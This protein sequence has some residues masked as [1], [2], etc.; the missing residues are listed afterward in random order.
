MRKLILKLSCSIIGYNGAGKSTLLHILSGFIK[1]TEGD[2]YCNF[3]D[4]KSKLNSIGFCSQDNTALPQNTIHENLVFW[5]RIK[6]VPRN[7]IDSEVDTMM[8]KLGLVHSRNALISSL[9]VEIRKRLCIAIA[10]LNN[11]QI[12]I[13]DEPTSG[14]DAAS[15]E[16]FRGIIREM[17]RDQKTVIFTTQFLDDAEQFVD[18]LTILS[19]GFY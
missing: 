17:K 10:L 11:P 3:Y 8:Q 15:R 13:M 14:L 7:L 1:Q 16:T 5:A 18:R 4:A 9:S 6:N 2:R 19:E 12:I